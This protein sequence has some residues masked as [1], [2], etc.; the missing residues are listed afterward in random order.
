QYKT[1]A[2]ISNIA[3]RMDLRLSKCVDGEIY[4]AKNNSIKQDRPCEGA[5]SRPSEGWSVRLFE[6][7]VSK[8]SYRQ[9]LC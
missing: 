4:L 9:A 2:V 7:T 8:N 1:Y 6:V 5:G 3:W